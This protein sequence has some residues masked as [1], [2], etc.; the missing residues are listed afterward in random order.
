MNDK[1]RVR[2]KLV[3]QCEK[4]DWDIGKTLLAEEVLLE[5]PDV[6]GTLELATPKFQKLARV[7]RT[8]LTDDYQEAPDNG[9]TK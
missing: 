8:Y 1:P 5:F 2:I 7:C 3:M 4:G 6:R 9:A